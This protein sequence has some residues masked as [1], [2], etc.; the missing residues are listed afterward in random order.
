M[1]AGGLHGTAASVPGSD[2][3]PKD[4]RGGRGEFQGMKVVEQVVTAVGRAIEFALT[5]QASFRVTSSEF[6]ST[7]TVDGSVQARMAM[8][9]LTA[10]LAEWFQIKLTWP[11][12]LELARPQGWSWKATLY[13]AEGNL[14]RYSPQELGERKAH[15]I[16]VTPG[17]TRPRFRAILG[18]EIVHAYQHER[19]ILTRNMA[20]RE[21]MA[22]WVEYHI[23]TKA[24]QSV[25]AARLLS[26]RHYLFGKAVGSVL[27]YEKNHGRERTLSWLHSP[28]ADQG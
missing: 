22:R 21:G 1:A 13:H 8:D 17:L 20:L 10:D 27:E 25:E 4:P 16:T 18:H 2:P 3:L 6:A 15:K 11:V 26:I 28:D 14:G 9:E 24:G 7:P 19:K 12:L 23:L 5:G